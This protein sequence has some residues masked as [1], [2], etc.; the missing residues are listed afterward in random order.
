MY[1]YGTLREFY[2]GGTS[3]VVAISLVNPLDVIKTRLQIAKARER[4]TMRSILA[5]IRRYEGI[6][7]FQRGLLPAVLFEFSTMGTRIATYEGLKK[8][9]PGEGLQNGLVCA[10]IAGCVSAVISC[11]FFLLKVRLQAGQVQNPPR[12]ISFRQA[13]QELVAEGAA[14]MGRALQAFVPRTA[15]CSVAMLLTYDEAKRAASV[16]LGLPEDATT[17]HAVAGAVAG[18]AVVLASNPLDVASARMLNFPGKYKNVVET[19]SRAVKAGGLKTLYK[20]AFPS[21]MLFVPYC[22]TVFLVAEY[23]RK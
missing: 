12:V 8:V 20:G 16:H 1:Q 22:T 14:P 15:V 17:V 3:A 6:R 19:M 4:S 2:I 21:F 13:A 7:G 5:N 10:S 9:F 11:P 23:L 18:A